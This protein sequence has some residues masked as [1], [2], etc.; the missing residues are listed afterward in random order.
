[1]RAGKPQG[2]VC[3]KCKKSIT[4]FERTKILTIKYEKGKRYEKVS[5]DIAQVTK[6]SI[7]LCEDCYKI[8]LK[9]MTNWVK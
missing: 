5:S 8:Y 9:N 3:D 6:D 2:A 4:P 7:D 1:M